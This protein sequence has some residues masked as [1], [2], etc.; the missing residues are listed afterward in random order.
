MAKGSTR[1]PAT[2]PAIPQRRSDP[3]SRR[4][5]VSLLHD[6]QA[7]ERALA[8]P[9]VDPAWRRRLAVRLGRLHGTFADHVV[10]TEGPDGLYAELLDHAPRLA[11]AVHVLISDHGA[12]AA[13]IA[14]LRRRVD[15]PEAGVDELRGWGSDLLRELSRHSERGADLVYQAYQLDIGGET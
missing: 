6:I 15:L 8:V 12:V 2:I 11:R 3:A 13:A 1:Q 14:A 9:A 7:V 5:Q 4:H 10:V